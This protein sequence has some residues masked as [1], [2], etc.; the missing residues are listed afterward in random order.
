MSLALLSVAIA[1]APPT[2][3]SAYAGQNPQSMTVVTGSV[4]L[5][6]SAN[7][8]PVPLQGAR[9]SFEAPG[10]FRWDPRETTYTGQD[11]HYQLNLPATREGPYL[12]LIEAPDGKR[13]RSREFVKI[14][15]DNHYDFTFLASRDYVSAF[16]DGVMKLGAYR[17]SAALMAA[18]AFQE[19]MDLAKRIA[20]PVDQVRIYGARREPYAPKYFKSQALFEARECVAL[21]LIVNDTENTIKDR[22]VKIQSLL[23]CP[24][25][26]AE[27][28][29]AESPALIAPEVPELSEIADNDRDHV[30]GETKEECEAAEGKKQDAEHGYCAA[31]GLLIDLNSLAQPR[32]RHVESVREPEQRRR[33]GEQTS[34]ETR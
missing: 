4:Y 33:G 1:F 10:W 8:S 19:A 15:S 24:L 20:K 23:M 26:R 21:S 7:D 18:G 29:P 27:L 30:A 17:G 22:A 32:H 28:F 9:V 5:K 11:G 2:V 14:G 12:L 31:K 34:P 3:V 6:P 16:R 25:Q 13:Q